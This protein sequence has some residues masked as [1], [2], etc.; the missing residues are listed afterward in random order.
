MAELEKYLEKRAVDTAALK[1][2][3]A[4]ALGGAGLGLLA[5]PVIRRLRRKKKATLSDY[6]MGAGLGAGAGAGAGRLGLEGVRRYLAN[7]LIAEPYGYEEG[8]DLQDKLI[9]TVVPSPMKDQVREAFDKAR[10]R[11]DRP[12]SITN[13]MQ[14]DA[15]GKA[16]MALELLRRSRSAGGLFTAPVLKELWRDITTK[17]SLGNI[18][19]RLQELEKQDIDPMQRKRLFSYLPGTLLRGELLSRYFNVFDPSEGSML[20]EVPRGERIIWNK[21]ITGDQFYRE[22]G[23]PSD[24]TFSYNTDINR[25]NIERIM[26]GVPVGSWRIIPGKGDVESN[27]PIRIGNL[28]GGKY[29][30][31]SSDLWDIGLNPGEKPEGTTNFLRDFLHRNI[32][33]KAVGLVN[34]EYIIE[35]WDE[36]GKPI[37]RKI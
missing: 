11:S 24:D 37:A 22:E 6:L 19:S 8:K 9:R 5:A 7:R 30:V 25:E 12:S 26:E 14:L 3:G 31:Q 28:G 20:K 17:P 34:P 35:A 16:V 4:G 13:I 23:G 18:R 1:W 27:M 33:G 21:N 32:A 29:S 15:S 2:A 36:Q 10:L